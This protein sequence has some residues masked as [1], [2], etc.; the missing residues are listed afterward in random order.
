MALRTPPGGGSRVLPPGRPC[1]TCRPQGGSPSDGLARGVNT[2]FAQESRAQ[3]RG[4]NDLD[5]D[6]KCLLRKGIP[7]LLDD[8]VQIMMPVGHGWKDF[9]LSQVARGQG[10]QPKGW[11]HDGRNNCCFG[12]KSPNRGRKSRAPGKHRE[13][14]RPR[15][16]PFPPR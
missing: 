4:R 9:G 8:H 15:P 14:R 7:S 3:V 5:D 1:R 6:G 11:I 10:H 16:C 2:L 12:S 13:S